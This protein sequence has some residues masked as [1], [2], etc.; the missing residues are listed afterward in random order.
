ML[1]GSVE[2]GSAESDWAEWQS[3]EYLRVDGKEVR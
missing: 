2:S 1:F 3:A